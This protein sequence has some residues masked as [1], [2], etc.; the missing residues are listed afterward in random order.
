MRTLLRPRPVRASGVL[1]SPGRGSAQ[2]R[3]YLAWSVFYFVG[4]IS[5]AWREYCALGTFVGALGCD[6]GFN[7]R[8]YQFGSQLT[9]SVHSHGKFQQRNGV[10]ERIHTTLPNQC[11][12]MRNIH[13]AFIF[14]T[15]FDKVLGLLM[16]ERIKGVSCS[17]NIVCALCCFMWCNAAMNMEFQCRCN[18]HI[19]SE[20]KNS[21]VKKKGIC[22]C[23]LAV[24]KSMATFH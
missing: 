20:G 13:G 22:R 17:Q 12:S 7:N 23:V 11:N 2:K 24:S 4:C 6:G 18:G 15:C 9:F 3:R 14:W 10:C 8:A 16:N 19:G 1:T 5:S 21:N